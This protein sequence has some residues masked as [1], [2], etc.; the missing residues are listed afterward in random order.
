LRRDRDAQGDLPVYSPIYLINPNSLVDVTARIARAVH[1]CAKPDDVPVHCVTLEAGPPGIVS[2]RDADLAAPLVADYVAHNEAHAAA[3]VIACYSDPGLHGAREATRK[4]V[5]GI[6][7]A[8]LSAALLLGERIGVIAVATGSIARHLRYYR[9]L[10]IGQRIAGERA[11]DL[12]VSES[13]DEAM[14]LRRLVDTAKALRDEDSADVIVLGCAGMGELRARVED[15]IALPVIDP[16]TAAVAFA[17]ARA[18]EAAGG[19]S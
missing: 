18:R 17:V 7:Q 5:I 11:I 14:A 8:G 1:A 12:S 16:C 3:F 13:G 6:G 15:A 10:G 9:T 19:R 2:Q 4:P